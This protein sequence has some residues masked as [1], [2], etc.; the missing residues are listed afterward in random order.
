MHYF[1]RLLASIVRD[2]LIV[3]PENVVMA[4]EYAKYSRII[5]ALPDGWTYKQQRYRIFH[6]RMVTTPDVDS[7][8][9]C[10]PYFK[11]FHQSWCKGP[12]T[13]SHGKSTGHK[14]PE[15]AFSHNFMPKLR[16]NHTCPHF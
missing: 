13:C 2:K 16:W 7:G 5:S 14:V 3:D 11:V 4:E 10:R 6:V 12:P 15:G 8:G 1:E 9:G